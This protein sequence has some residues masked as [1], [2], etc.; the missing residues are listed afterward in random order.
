MYKAVL[1][2]SLRVSVLVGFICPI[3]CLGQS[4]DNARFEKFKQLIETGNDAP[5]MGFMNLSKPHDAAR[6]RKH[7]EEE[8]TKKNKTACSVAHCGA[9]LLEEDFFTTKC[10]DVTGRAYGEGWMEVNRKR[11]KL[12]DVVTIRC[13]KNA[14]VGEV[15]CNINTK[16]CI[17][18]LVRI[19]GKPVMGLSGEFSNADQAARDACSGKISRS[20]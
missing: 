3:A 6:M 8:C 4:F 5:A 10:A 7:A 2:A 13:Q 12:L 20:K 18:N 16:A 9:G 15:R 11:D 19:E 1:K 17:H 14:S